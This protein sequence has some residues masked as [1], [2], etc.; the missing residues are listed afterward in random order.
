MNERI[1]NEKYCSQMN[2]IDQKRMDLKSKLS[3]KP[4]AQSASNQPPRDNSSA[5]NTSSRDDATPS[6]NSMPKDPPAVA[7]NGAPKE[8]NLL[9]RT[10]SASGIGTTK[11]FVSPDYSNKSETSKSQKEK[12][13]EGLKTMM[14]LKSKAVLN[15]TDEKCIWMSASVEDLGERAIRS[16]A[17][18]IEKLL[19][20]QSN[21]NAATAASIL[22]CFPTCSKRTRDLGERK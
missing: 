12:F 20:V 7:S 14:P 15:E 16:K 4:S 1:G 6:K 9:I 3:D 22:S 19:Y 18:E 21:K 5:S 2:G 8:S 11:S 13:H 17:A 10:P